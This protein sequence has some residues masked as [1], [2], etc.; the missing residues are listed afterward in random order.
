MPDNLLKR[1]VAHRMPLADWD[2]LMDLIHTAE[3]KRFAALG[4]RPP[5]GSRTLDISF[6][7]GPMADTKRLDN[8]LLGCWQR[9]SSTGEDVDMI[10]ESDGRLIYAIASGTTWAVMILTWCVDGDEIVS[11]QHSAPGLR[12]TRYSIDESGCLHLDYEGEHSVFRRGT[13]R[14]PDV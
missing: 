11:D 1:P 10:F 2:E 4:L 9:A 3:C 14:V 12:R 13:R 6:E 8:S 7:V 5:L